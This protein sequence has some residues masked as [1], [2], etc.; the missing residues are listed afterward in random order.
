MKLGKGLAQLGKGLVKSVAGMPDSALIS[1][2]IE[3]GKLGL[4][5]A[6]ASFAV[7]TYNTLRHVEFTPARAQRAQR[8]AQRRMSTSSS[9]AADIR[10]LVELDVLHSQIF[11]GT[12]GSACRWE[13]Q[14]AFVVMLTNVLLEPGATG[15]HLLRPPA[16][17]IEQLCNGDGHFQGL[18]Q[19][20]ALGAD[21][22]TKHDSE[23]LVLLSMWSGRL[24]L[25]DDV[26]AWL[27][28]GIS[29][30]RAAVSSRVGDAQIQLEAEC[31][32]MLR[33]VVEELEHVTADV[34]HVATGK[35]AKVQAKLERVVECIHKIRSGLGGVRALTV[36][37]LPIFVKVHQLVASMT[38]PDEERERRIQRAVKVARVVLG[39]RA[40]AATTLLR[41]I[42][43]ARE[44]RDAAAATSAAAVQAAATTAAEGEGDDMSD[45]EELDAIAIELADDLP[46]SAHGMHDE[47]HDELHDTASYYLS[48]DCPLDE[49]LQQVLKLTGATAAPRAGSIDA[50]LV[51]VL[52]FIECGR[53]VVEEVQSVADA[54]DETLKT[55]FIEPLE[56]LIHD[57]KRLVR[58]DGAK[59]VDGK[60]RVHRRS[61]CTQ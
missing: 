4:D 55:V 52:G 42:T 59:Q 37:L 44:K 33:P 27:N 46:S 32:R 16:V 41:L 14:A 2:A 10:M 22:S 40:G 43:E 13:A 48:K 49:A 19:L 53:A 26:G 6:R 17:L 8:A 57:M 51:R 58:H 7:C 60:R 11:Q 5:V 25:A 38:T 15:S 23:P 54:F 34:A 18:S 31:I 61:H 56:T 47:L 20:L 12:A 29:I 24:F 1:G 3:L 9:V 30:L 39:Q 45:D 50:Y 28:E 35:A 21:T 36:K